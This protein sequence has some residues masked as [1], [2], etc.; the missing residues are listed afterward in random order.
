MVQSGLPR[1][2]FNGS[3]GFRYLAESARARHAANPVDE[4]RHGPDAVDTIR[5]SR[6]AHDHTVGTHERCNEADSMRRRRIPAPTDQGF[7]HGDHDRPAGQD[8]AF[9][10]RARASRSR[11]PM[12]RSRSPARPQP[13]PCYMASDFNLTERRHNHR[14]AAIDIDDVRQYGSV[15]RKAITVESPSQCQSQRFDIC[16]P[17]TPPTPL[18][19]VPKTLGLPMSDSGQDECS[20]YYSE[21]EF[22]QARPSYVSPLRVHKNGDI[23]NTAVLLFRSLS[24][25]SPS[26][27][28]S[29]NCYSHSPQRLVFHL[30]SLQSL[31]QV[32][33]YPL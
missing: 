1:Y 5:F 16:P 17:N 31:P 15:S 11:S 26:S 18:R 33:S 7:H 3:E 21:E 14:P 9:S 28:R 29:P 6:S 24:G 4:S 10:S 23:N 25:N 8:D 13:I 2:H 27:E 32:F 12:K 22:G 19:R 20:S 30:L